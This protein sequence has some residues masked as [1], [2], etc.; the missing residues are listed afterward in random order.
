MNDGYL[1]SMPFPFFAGLVSGPKAAATSAIMN[2]EVGASMT[3][4]VRGALQTIQK[5]SSRKHSALRGACDQVLEFA[6]KQS[7]QFIG[8]IVLPICIDYGCTG[9]HLSL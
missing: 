7:P 9:A 8:K 3:H 4:L 5:A 6:T 1:M 2:D